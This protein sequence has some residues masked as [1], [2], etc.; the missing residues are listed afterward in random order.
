MPTY[1]VSSLNDS[2]AVSAFVIEEEVVVKPIRE[3]VPIDY[4]EEEKLAGASVQQRIAATVARINSR[5]EVCVLACL[6]SS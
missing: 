6:K 2:P 4:T 1:L 5:S 3:L